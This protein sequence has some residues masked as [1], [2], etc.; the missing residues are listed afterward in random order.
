MCPLCPF[1]SRELKDPVGVDPPPEGLTLV[2][3]LT[4]NV[5]PNTRG[6]PGTTPCSPAPPFCRLA[7][8]DSGCEWW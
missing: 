1:Y 2:S 6:G 4:R 5:L 8:C 7:V 3:I